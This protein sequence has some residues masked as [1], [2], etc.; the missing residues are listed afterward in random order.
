VGV[1]RTKVLTMP[2]PHIAAAKGE[3]AETVLL[4][5]DPLRAKFIAEKFL[6]DAKLVTAVRNM[7]GYTGTY[8]GKRISVMGTGMGIPSFSIYASE[9]ARFYDVKTLIRIGSCGSVLEKVKMG[10]IVF[11]MGAASD[12]S[13]YSVRYKYHFTPNADYDLLSTAVNISREKE[14]DHHVGTVFTSDLFYHPDP[15]FFDIVEKMGC[16]GLEMEVAA[17]YSIAQEF[18]VR[19]L[20]MCTVSDEIR[21]TES[22]ERTFTG[23][24]PEEREKSLVKM[25]EVAL[26]TAIS[27]LP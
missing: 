4:P 24:K 26:E 20:G 3:F 19:A 13:L 11:A 1:E 10:D 22:G 21:K 2:T 18:G 23:L 14:F 15:E 6:T 27:F 9:L 5:G 25:M 12:S 16:V 7:Y 17:L 8:K